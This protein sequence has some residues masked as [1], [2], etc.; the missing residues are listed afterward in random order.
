MP[1]RGPSYTL[2]CATLL[3]Q[4][5]LVQKRKRLSKSCTLLFILLLFTIFIMALEIIHGIECVCKDH[6]NAY[7]CLALKKVRRRCASFILVHIEIVLS[8]VE[9]VNDTTHIPDNIKVGR[10]DKGVGMHHYADQAVDLGRKNV[11]KGE[12][13]RCLSLNYIFFVGKKQKCCNL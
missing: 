7:K 12:Q 3:G 2:E 8:R 1:F 11:W 13:G 5:V 4:L 10:W 6:F 9:L